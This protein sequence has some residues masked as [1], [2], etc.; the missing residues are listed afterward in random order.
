MKPASQL[1]VAALLLTP[2]AVLAQTPQSESGR[3]RIVS[4]VITPERPPLHGA[5]YTEPKGLRLATISRV[6]DDNGQSWTTFNPKPD[7]TA[8][9]P[10]GYR[11]EALTSVVDPKSLM[12]IRNSMLEVD[13]KRPE[14]DDRGREL[15][16]NFNGHVD[17]SHFRIIEDRQTG[18][19]V[20]T[21]PRAYGGYLK[22]DWATVRIA[23]ARQPR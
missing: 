4:R 11:G 16:S 9:L 6:S 21:Y 20:L 22:S 23:I 17:L 19:L 13:T 18:E 14:D 10:Y 15:I 12:L 5:I 1:L 8:G 3:P 7:F 2:L